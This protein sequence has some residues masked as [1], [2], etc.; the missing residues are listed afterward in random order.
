LTFAP[1]TAEERLGALRAR[2]K[3]WRRSGLLNAEEERGLLAATLTRWTGSGIVSRLVYFAL[4]MVCMGALYGLI[5]LAG[6]PAKPIA[7]VLALAAAELLI[8]RFG[9][10]R[11]GPDEALYAGGL[12]LIVASLPAHSDE[13]G[14]LLVALGMLLAGARLRNG[15]FLMVSVAAVV[16][17]VAVAGGSREIAAFIGLAVS[18]ASVA[19]LNRRW[20]H[21]VWDRFFSWTIVVTPAL[22]WLLVTVDADISRPWVMGVTGFIA[23]VM[24]LVGLAI[25]HH[26][27]LLA[28]LL[29]S[30]AAIAELGFRVAL[31]AEY[32]VI[33]C[34]IAIGA[35]VLIL[36][37]TFG[38]R[39]AGITAMKILDARE[40][41]LIE[42][43]AAAVLAGSQTRAVEPAGMQTGGGSYGGG[44]ASGEF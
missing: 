20:S 40:L 3:S 23:A 39:H 2:L 26:A 19:L 15:F 21:P 43:A 41:E 29:L 25:R 14:I 5:D 36:H 42:P 24:L 17:Y 10:F 27:P 34:G 6:L 22:S 13:V 1:T 4:T 7:A 30:G 33:T 8:L 11:A 32:F 31:P 37:R 12:L 35:V 18:F 28:G 38:G 44:G 16:L 9:L